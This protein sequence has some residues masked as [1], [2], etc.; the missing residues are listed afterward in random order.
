MNIIHPIVIHQVIM[1]KL[2]LIISM[3]LTVIQIIYE[4]Y[5]ES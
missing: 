2:E 4:G 5:M 1:R 3:V